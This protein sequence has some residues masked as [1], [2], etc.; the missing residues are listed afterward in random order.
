MEN[1]CV[2]VLTSFLVLHTTL[3]TLIVS[4][5][6]FVRPSFTKKTAIELR[7]LLGMD[8]PIIPPKIQIRKL[9]LLRAL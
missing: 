6:N 8:L 9:K 7:N 4:H 3:S 5:K 2:G 1:L